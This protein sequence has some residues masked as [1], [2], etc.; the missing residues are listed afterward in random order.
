MTKLLRSIQFCLLLAPLGL[1][2]RLSAEPVG[3]D[4]H[5]ADLDSFAQA[6]AEIDAGRDATEAMRGYLDRASPALKAFAATYGTTPEKIVQQLQKRPKYYR[7]FTRIRPKLEALRPAIDTD[8]RRLAEI[9][10]GPQ[11]AVHFVVA[12][13]V[14]G[15][16]PRQVTYPDG[17]T[18]VVI[19]VAVDL[20]G[21]DAET[22]MAEFPVPL[23]I[24]LADL[25][26]IIVHEMVHVLQ[27]RAQGGLANYRSIYTDPVKGT[28]LAFA[29]REGT[30]EF[31]TFLATGRR[32][33]QRHIYGFAREAELWEAFSPVMLE[34]QGKHPEWFSGGKS[35]RFPDLPMQTG[36]FIGMQ[37]CQTFHDTASDKPGA[38][39]RLMRAW[40]AEDFAAIAAPYV[41]RFSAAVSR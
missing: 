19:V 17:T 29:I 39:D 38:L 21:T 24:T 7:A 10:P 23:P 12:Q 32:L 15:A 1:L 35:T 26:Q 18:G 3:A 41:A 13:S 2:P 20:L 16:T 11:C 34:P 31:V 30:A 5:Y 33:G 25:P 14:A 40:T 36:Y 27:V 6:V 4:F 9:T 22:D 28:L 37:I 8:L